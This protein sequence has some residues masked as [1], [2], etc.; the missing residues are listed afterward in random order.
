MF[1]PVV[2]CKRDAK[3]CSSSLS[4]SKW[5]CPR[6]GPPASYMDILW[7]KLGPGVENIQ[8]AGWKRDAGLHQHVHD[9]EVLVSYSGIHT[10][11]QLRRSWTSRHGMGWEGGRVGYLYMSCGRESHVGEISQ[12]LTFRSRIA[13]VAIEGLV[14]FGIWCVLVCHCP[15]FCAAGLKLNK[16][17]VRNENQTES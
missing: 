16:V 8:R 11:M 7:E 2:Q 17:A 15:H 13:L 3:G 6:L 9:T 1:R 10:L 5:T 14:I 12:F 4:N